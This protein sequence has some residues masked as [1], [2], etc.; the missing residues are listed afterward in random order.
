MKAK[1]AGVN[2]VRDKEDVSSS[3]AM[4]TAVD[5]VGLVRVVTD[6]LEFKAKGTSV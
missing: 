5:M 4:D 2:V 6:Y 1:I 3:A